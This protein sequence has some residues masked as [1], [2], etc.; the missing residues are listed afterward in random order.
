MN[1][2]KQEG[3]HAGAG[4]DN[5]R[6]WLDPSVPEEHP[7]PGPAPSDFFG[8]SQ[9]GELARKI[10]FEKKRLTERPTFRIRT[11]LTLSFLAVFSL[12]VGITFW[13]IYTLSQLENKIHF[14]EVADSYVSE[15]QQ[16]RRFEKNF[17][18]YG[19]NLD[20]ALEHLATAKA[21]LELN[22]ATAEHVLGKNKLDLLS[23]HVEDY[24][25]LLRKLG[26]TADRRDRADIESELRAHGSQMV[27]FALDFAQKER[28]AIDRTFVLA[29]RV[30][31]VFLVVLLATMLV[32]TM[33]LTRQLLTTL[34]RFM[35]YARR[36]G[37]G[38]FSPIT[39]ARP[40][41]DEFSQLALAFNQMI[42][43]L[44]RRHRILI[45]S[46]KI[47]AIGTLVA[48]VAHEL[49]NP[50]NNIL[51]TTALLAEDFK[52]LGEDEIQEMLKDI[53]G[54]TERS[55]RIVRNLLDFARESEARIRPL[56]LPA[57]IE[58]AVKLVA[59]QVR[60]AK[61]RL[62]VD[63][64]EDLPPIHGD[65]QMLSQVF[66]NL[67][68]NAVDVLP[69][70]GEIRIHAHRGEVDNFVAVDFAD[71]GPGIPPH[72]LNRI[73]EPFF[74]TKTKGKGTGLGL[75]VSHG[76]VRKLGGYIRVSSKV[77]EGT[78]FRV[79]LPATNIPFSITGGTGRKRE[80]SGFHIP[81]STDSDSGAR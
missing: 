30:P 9:E 23:R 13:I 71:N 15:I 20:D 19:T 64:D 44:E 16:A 18:L 63:I 67:I 46:H 7:S 8:V 6:V 51:L 40:F 47:R 45:E 81:A 17:L 53:I 32:I 52:E 61:I 80:E 3:D 1:G 69:E 31:F 49:N 33:F 5:G 34:A 55:Q 41:R 77:G 57:I 54:E 26:E 74:T 25:R 2:K 29:R 70:K 48:G 68:L 4:A 38:D 28:Q 10:E 76:I 56:Q 14:L 73:F 72:L 66:V 27:A 11:R 50:L 12:C 62:T 58:N 42:Y 59:N 43:E 22:R 78:V 79:L 39:P 36:I 24:E 75:S 37:E 60:L 21:K 65:D 35:T